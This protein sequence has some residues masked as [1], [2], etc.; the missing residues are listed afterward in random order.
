VAPTYRVK[1]SIG[2]G[3][4]PTK[5]HRKKRRV[6]GY[7]E[8]THYTSQI[9]NLKEGKRGEAISDSRWE[10]K[11][12]T[13]GLASSRRGKSNGMKMR[14]A[15]GRLH[16]GEWGWRARGDR[17]NEI[18]KRRVRVHERLTTRTEK[19]TSKRLRREDRGKARRRKIQQE[20]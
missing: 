12:R 4:R 20:E 7:A 15:I 1:Q 11:G 8:T 13:G 17:G 16:N 3:E 19:I 9:K 6:G 18:G 10:G 14:R 5:T 2:E